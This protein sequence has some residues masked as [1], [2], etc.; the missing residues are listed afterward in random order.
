[1]IPEASDD[2]CFIVKINAIGIRSTNEVELL[3]LTIGHKLK[4]DAPKDK[5]RK[6]ARFRKFLSTCT[7]KFISKFICK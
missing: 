3:G 7:G 1:M 2:K 4:L 6:T 5:L